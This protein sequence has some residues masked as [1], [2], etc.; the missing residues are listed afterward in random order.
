MTLPSSSSRTPLTDAQK[1]RAKHP[2]FDSCGICRR[3][4]LRASKAGSGMNCPPGFWMNKRE[5]AAWDKGFRCAE[6]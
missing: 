5:R 1:R 2:G 3:C 4:G 6:Y